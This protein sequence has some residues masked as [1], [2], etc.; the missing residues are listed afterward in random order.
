MALV[1]TTDMLA[2]CLRGKYAVGHHLW[3]CPLARALG[4]AAHPDAYVGIALLGASE[5]GGYEVAFASL[6]DACRMAFGEGGS[7]V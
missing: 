7:F 3:R 6:H 1:K 5:I 2:A 4:L